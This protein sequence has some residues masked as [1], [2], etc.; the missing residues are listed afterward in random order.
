MQSISDRDDAG[1]AE[2]L[3]F[4]ELVCRFYESE[5]RTT[6]TVEFGAL[7]HVGK[8]REVNEDHYL[9][10]RR[11]RLRELVMTSLPVELLERPEQVAY[12]LA[13]AD[14][15]GGHAFGEIAS[16]LALKTGWELGDAEVKWALKMNER[17]SADL[18]EKAV[19]FFRLIDRRLHDAAREQPRLAG[20]GTTLT[21]CYTTGPELFVMHAGDSLAY[22]FRAGTL[23]R[24]TRDHTV[25]QL[26][27][28]AGAA[29]PGSPEERKRRHM[30]TNFLG[31]PT[32]SVEVDVDHHH[33]EDGDL[34]LL[35]TDGL[36]GQ[37]EDREI[38]AILDG[39]PA[40]DDACRALVDRALD[41]GGKDNITVV[42]ARFSFP[43]PFDPASDPAR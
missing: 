15:M 5:P 25:A 40:P 34:L 39:H 6:T 17:E 24:L 29:A 7:T 4:D 10:V 9:V 41:R 36:H 16:F 19:V 30:L 27:I 23:R 13:V 37:V 11:R 21:L 28:D 32:V 33:L 1:T 3:A 20:M 42:L 38:A 8:V 12:T 43:D 18:K 2:F 22:L 14:G 26:L 35:C 31:G